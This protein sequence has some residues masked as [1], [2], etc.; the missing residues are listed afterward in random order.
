MLSDY[1]RVARTYA[2]WGPVE[3][4]AE[5]T[6]FD[7]PFASEVQMIEALRGFEV[8]CVMRERIPFD[9][10]LISALHE[11]RCIVTTGAANRSIDLGAAAEHGVTVSGTTNGLGRAAT[12]ELTWALILAASRSL[13]FEDR[14]LRSG[15]WQATV[16]TVLRGATIGI[17]GLG[18]VGRYVA[19][20]AHAFDMR[21]LAWSKNLTEERAAES[22][23]TSV[24][25]DE[26]LERSDVITLHLVLSDETRGLIDAA[27]IDRMRPS[28]LLVNTSRGPLIDDAALV[29]ALRNRK[30]R[31]AA[32]D[33]FSEEPLPMEH[34]YR[35]LDNV[36]LTPHLGYVTED[37]YREF[38]TETVR[39]AAA[40]FDGAPIRVLNPSADP[41]VEGRR[42]EDLP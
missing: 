29:E 1:Q 9:R 14:T 40:Y 21:V 36:V 11:L 22:G 5:I 31:G 3:A 27:A 4:H 34:P 25:K 18:G 38:F 15:G 6:V 39:S 26:L 16:G 17:A 20:Y 19:R 24:S 28:A 10:T 12:A 41:T 23:A 7:R 13:P 33:V 8:V 32:L 2:D 35:T 30:I 42:Y 37:V